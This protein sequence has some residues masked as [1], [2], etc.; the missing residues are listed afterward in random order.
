MLVI[1]GIVIG[2]DSTANGTY[3]I[4]IVVLYLSTA[5]GADSIAVVLGM[6]AVRRGKG[7]AQNQVA[8]ADLQSEIHGAATGDEQAIG[9]D[10]GGVGEFV[11]GNG[12]NLALVAIGH[13][14]ILVVAGFDSYV[15]I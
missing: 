1:I 12:G 4:G 6:F 13:I 3:T 8:A 7:V 15:A 5:E 10:G 2:I 14:E 11:Q 9:T